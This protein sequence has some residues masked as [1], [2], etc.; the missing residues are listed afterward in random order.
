[1]SRKLDEIDNT[2]LKAL[3][4]NG[5]QTVRALA[6]EV[7]L[8]EPSVRD[9]LLRLEREGVITGYH[10]AVDPTAVGGSTAAFVALRFQPSEISKKAMNEAL[11]AEPCVIEAH[12][13]AGEDCYLLKLRVESTHALAE[14]LDRLKGHPTVDTRTT[15]VLRTIFERPMDPMPDASREDAGADD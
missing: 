15:I 5:R 7:S 4:T 14:A 6:Q 9:R 10:A 13:V 3:S 1:M 2:L 11:L 12:E 8:S